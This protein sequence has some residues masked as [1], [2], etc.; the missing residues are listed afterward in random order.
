[1]V[2]GR[3]PT[4]DALG[5]THAV[6]KNKIESYKDERPHFIYMSMRQKANQ[7]IRD[8]Q[9]YKDC[10]EDVYDQ[11]AASSTAASKSCGLQILLKVRSVLL[12]YGQEMRAT[13]KAKSV[14][15]CFFNMK[16]PKDIP[17]SNKCYRRKCK[18]QK[19]LFQTLAAD[20]EAMCLILFLE[21]QMIK[22]KK[23]TED[24]KLGMNHALF[25]LNGKAEDALDDLRMI[26]LA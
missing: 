7:F 10:I 12:D 3:L 6:F 9:L 22:S 1:M 14:Q 5:R 25:K 11:I 26:V 4:L 13:G 21:K 18:K 19:I 15:H 20:I 24:G 17:E 8:E 2:R 16:L 23:I